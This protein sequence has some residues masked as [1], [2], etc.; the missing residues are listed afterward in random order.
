MASEFQNSLP[1][2]YAGFNGTHKVFIPMGFS[3]EPNC[4]L[5]ESGAMNKDL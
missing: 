2:A 5:K 1:V 3:G 4:Q